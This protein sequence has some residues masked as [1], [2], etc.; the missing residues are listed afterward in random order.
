MFRQNTDRDWQTLAQVDPY[1]AVLTDDRFHKDRLTADAVQ[2]FFASGEAHVASVFQCIRR[3]IDPEF[4][5]ATALDFGCGVGR[6]LI[7]L[8]PQCHAVVG[9]DVAPAMLAEAR[10]RCEAFGLTN[11]RFVTADDRLSELGEKF[12]FI[13]SYI[14][15]QH[16][17][18]SRGTAIAR[19][20]LE[21]LNDGGVGAL[22]F[23]Y[24][25]QPSV[26]HSIHAR[27]RARARTTCLYPVLRRLLRLAGRL[28]RW[29]QRSAQD[30]PAMQMNCY[31]L[32]TLVRDLQ[33]AGVREL[34]VELLE[35]EGMLGVFLIFQ[36]GRTA[37]P[38]G[39]RQQADQEVP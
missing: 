4:S 3:H 18:P 27:L 26:Q 7:P 36:K 5:P 17:P 20:L 19:R 14:V 9:M 8:A 22:H 35:D 10:A 23:T 37:S 16:I 21:H 33:Q 31:D 15:F 34:H 11:V 38:R 12:D 29:L 39:Q 1:W 6:I 25:Y 32:N 28:G 30:R 24:H 13:H 2:D